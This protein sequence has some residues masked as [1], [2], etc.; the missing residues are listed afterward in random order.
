MCRNREETT[1]LQAQ[2]CNAN[3]LCNSRCS[4]V[5]NVEKKLS[6]YL[7]AVSSVYVYLIIDYNSLLTY[8]INIWDKMM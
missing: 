5:N 2:H 7:F 6:S 3:N 4:K 8:I 1:Y